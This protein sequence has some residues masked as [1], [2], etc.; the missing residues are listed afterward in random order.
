MPEVLFA[1]DEHN[2]KNCQNSFRGEKNQDYYLGDYSIEAGST[3]NVSAEKTTVGPNSVMRLRSSNRLRFR[4]SWPHIRQDSI[5]VTV[6]WFVKRGR[7]SV[8]T[9]SGRST[10][11]KG[12]LVITRSLTPFHSECDAGDD[13]M[14]DVVHVVVPTHILRNYIPDYVKTGFV[15]SVDRPECM[16]IERIFTDI[17]ENGDR[18]VHDVSQLLCESALSVLGAAIKMSNSG[19]PRQSIAEQRF[20]EVL[21]YIEVHLSDSNLSSTMV[22]KGCGIST[23]YLCFLFQLHNTSFSTVLWEQR[24]Q[25]AK[26]WLASSQPNEVT[27]TEIAYGLGFK[28][29]P[30]FSRMFKRV[31]KMSPRQVRLRRDGGTE[32]TLCS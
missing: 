26:A 21:R 13:G 5:D 2:Y 7:I 23:R 29:Q 20:Q 6:I 10:A 22:A 9:Q 32:A 28:S 4:R 8:T 14:L 1:F 12:H 18:M 24:L 31:F 3:I 15:F 30:H 16:I 25:K 19:S 27:V 11:K 17:L